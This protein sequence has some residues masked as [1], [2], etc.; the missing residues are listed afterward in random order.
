MDLAAMERA[1][2]RLD[3]ALRPIAGRRVDI[4]DP[5]WVETLESLRPLDEAGIRTEAETLLESILLRYSSG[6]EATRISIRRL[7]DRCSAFRW[8]GSLVCAP[9]TAA[10][11]RLHLLHLSVRDQASDARDELLVLQDLCAQATKSG[12]D[13][14]P[15]LKEVAE[16]SSDVDKYGMGSTKRLL[17]D[18]C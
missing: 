14:V 9:T 1:V 5:G 15:I 6:D 18:A 3:S 11:F 7:F 12:V 2:E 8:A 16:L 4:S 17:L 10:G 13:I